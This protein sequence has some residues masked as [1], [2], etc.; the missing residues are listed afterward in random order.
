MFLEADNH[1]ILLSWGYLDHLGHHDF[2]LWDHGREAQ[3]SSHKHILIFL[4]LASIIFGELQSIHDQ[5][6][7]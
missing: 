5:Y 7:H 1:R 4:G 6:L 2:V 3:S